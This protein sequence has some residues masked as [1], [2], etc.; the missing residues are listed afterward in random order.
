[1][2]W[3]PSNRAVCVDAKL[4]P[5]EFSAVYYVVAVYTNADGSQSISLV[6]FPPEYRFIGTRFRQLVPSSIPAP[7]KP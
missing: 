5:L 1:M 6:G 7:R 2:N 3:L 4:S